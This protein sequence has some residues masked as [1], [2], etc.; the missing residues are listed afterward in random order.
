MPSQ[1]E[2][3]AATYERIADTWIG[4]RKN[5]N[6]RRDDLDDL[7]R[8]VQGGR[9]LD[10]GCGH[11]RYSELL[12][13]AGFEYLGIDLSPKMIELAR[14]G[15]P[16]AK[17][18]VGDMYDLSRFGTFDA[19]WSIASLVHIPKERTGA[20]L[21]SYR[22]AMNPGAIAA[23]SIKEGEGEHMEPFEG[24]PENLRLMVYWGLDEFA[25]AADAGGFTIRDVQRRE[26]SAATFLTFYLEA[27][28][29]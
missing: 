25:S 7:L 6:N 17:F 15:Y 11:G 3:T 21:D 22:H 1:E 27:E 20:V 18:E 10:A 28:H 14:G 5:P 26:R 23:I 9:V 13:G 29:D 12:Q 24:G 4:E 8:F 2:V 19:I 16:D